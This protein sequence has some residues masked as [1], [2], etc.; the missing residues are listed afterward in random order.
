MSYL[1]ARANELLLEAQYLRQQGRALRKEAAIRA[2]ELSA[3][4]VR[5]ATA[6]R[7]SDAG[8]PAEPAQNPD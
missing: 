5:T 7:G 3:T 4:V 1:L 8:G 6:G 2:S